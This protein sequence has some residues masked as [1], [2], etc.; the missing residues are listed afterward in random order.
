M[1]PSQRTKTEQLLAEGAKHIAGGVVS[2]NRK[3][4]INIAFV[5]AQGSKLYDADGNEYID[6]HAAFAPYLLGHNDP[7]VNGAV[8]KAIDEGWS[9]MGTGTTPWEVELARLLREA[10]PT[11]DLIQI[12]NSGSEA[13]AHAVRLSRAYTGRDGVILMLAGY[14]G[15]HNDVARAVM[16]PLEVIGPRVSPGEYP[17]LPLSAGM[18]DSVTQ[19]IHIVNFNDLDSVEHVLKQG[20]VACVMTEQVLQNVG[21][22]PPQPGYLE[23]LR[24]LCDQYGALL[25]FDEVKTGFRSALG[26]YQSISGVTPDL[27]VFGKAVANGYPLAVIGGKA[28]VMGLFD[29]PDPSRRVLI[30]GTYNA[31]PISSAATIATLERLMADG[32]AVYTQLEERGAQLQQGLEDLY[33]EHNVEATV[34][35]IGSAFSTY[36]ADHVPVDWHDLAASHDFEFDR[37]YRRA[38]I[39]KGV[40]HFPTPTKQGSISAAHTKEDIE[41][42]LQITHEVLSEL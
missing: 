3:T 41:K 15:W 30:A 20:T 21:V 4:D 17:F 7:H 42:T 6:Y 12:A 9:L 1:S 2:L 24:D 26:G 32:G 18:P 23:G 38:L 28:G 27:S 35:R 29:D 5:R 39:E 40:Y 19:H 36:F 11:L 31:H 22:I 13:T 8:K 37:R 33:L 25:V 14:N 16:P 10:V 34:S